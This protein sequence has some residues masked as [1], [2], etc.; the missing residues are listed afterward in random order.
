LLHYNT[1]NNGIVK[2]ISAGRNLYVSVRAFFWWIL[3]K[4]VCEQPQYLLEMRIR[5]FEQE[6]R[7]QEN[8]SKTT[9]EE[10]MVSP[11]AKKGSRR[12]WK[13]DPRS[14]DHWFICLSSCSRAWGLLELRQRFHRVWKDE[15]QQIRKSLLRRSRRY[16]TRSSPH[17]SSFLISASEFFRRHLLESTFQCVLNTMWSEII[18]FIAAVESQI[19]LGW[20]HKGKMDDVNMNICNWLFLENLGKFLKIEL[21]KKSVKKSRNSSEKKE[22]HSLWRFI[23]RIDKRIK[24]MCG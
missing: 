16:E 12:F 20:R 21:K 13:V 24:R 8:K 22:F 5:I 2:K 23:M 7:Q 11:A 14:L 15:D 3:F 10:I 4:I 19:D 17:H 18:N 1:Y 9:I 6:R